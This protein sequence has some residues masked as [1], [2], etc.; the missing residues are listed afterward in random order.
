MKG[1]LTRDRAITLGF[2]VF[3]IALALWQRPGWATSDTKIDL[4]VDPG[5]FLSSVASVWT[6][7][8]DL[9]EVHSAQYSGY[10]WP[11]GP[12]FA[13]LHSI[14][15]GAWLVQRLWLA[16]LFALAV[17]GMLKLLDALI[18]RPRGVAHVVAT[19][20]FLLNPYV[21][22]F[23]A[24]TTITLLGYAA[25]PWLLLITYRGVRAAAAG[26]TCA[27]GCGRPRSPWS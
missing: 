14:G 16:V 24:R 13:A 25:L 18:G 22:V 23:T 6:S 11:M 19:A 2:V 9:G 10:L 5:R 7:T 15:I 26:A 3:S 20:F 4:Q 21:A 1:R 17:W 12:F 27:G 8:T